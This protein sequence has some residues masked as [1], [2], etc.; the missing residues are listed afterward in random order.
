VRGEARR[1]G[2]SPYRDAITLRTGGGVS[3][4]TALRMMAPSLLA[5]SGVRIQGAQ[6]AADGSFTAG[7][8]SAVECASGTCQ[9]T[10]APYSAALVTV[11]WH[12]PV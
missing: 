9:L 12:G 3:S 4:A 10:L 2:R 11:S 5:T 6:V 8:P 1:P 7:A